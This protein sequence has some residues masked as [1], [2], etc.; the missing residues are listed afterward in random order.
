M[1]GAIIM[2]NTIIT[3]RV[4]AAVT[5]VEATIAVTTDFVRICQFWQMRNIFFYQILPLD[6][7]I[8]IG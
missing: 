3:M 2:E 4:A 6:K 8:I 1:F 5:V 7:S